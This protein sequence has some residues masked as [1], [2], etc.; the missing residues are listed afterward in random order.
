MTEVVKIPT[1]QVV[2]R[3]DVTTQTVNTPAG[4]VRVQLASTPQRITTREGTA[5][6]VVTDHVTVKQ[7]V[8]GPQGVPGETPNE[9]F[10]ATA[11]ETIHGERVV[12]LVNDVAYH[13]DIAENA[14][15]DQVIG[16][17][18]NSALIGE[19]VVIRTKGIMTAGYW[20]WT[21]GYVFVGLG[22]QLTQ[23]PAQDRWLLE[24][25]RVKSPTQIE[26]DVEVP[27][28]RSGGDAPAPL[29]A[30]GA[31]AEIG[32]SFEYQFEVFSSDPVYFSIVE[33][34]LPAGLTLT[35]D[36]LITGTLI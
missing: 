2:V 11:G 24:I 9:T 18:L 22:G 15:A 8:Q 36:G 31:E 17:A 14:H 29:F 30:Y 28:F 4:G 6:R 7:V 5:D 13:P 20:N 3:R 21:P 16:I 34:S 12:R 32:A 27:V 35:S 26:V 1:D 23:T 33:G 19:P 10:T 25:A